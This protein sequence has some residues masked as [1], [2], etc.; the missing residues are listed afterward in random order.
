MTTRPRTAARR[1]VLVLGVLA[2]VA[3]ACTG[4]QADEP[5]KPGEGA[6]VCGSTQRGPAQPPDD[7]VVV[8]PDVPADLTTA[9]QENPAGTTFWL[10]TGT[11]ILGNGE[12]DQVAPKNGNTYLAAPGA[13]LDGRETNRYAF[14]GKAADVTITHLTVRG[15][16][17]PVNEGV[18]NHDSGAGWTLEH[19]TLADNA[20]AALMAGDKQVM[21]GNCFRDNGQY[22]LNACCGEITDVTLE[23]NEFVGN[24]VDDVEADNPGCGCT[25]AMKFWDIDGADI[26]GNWIHDNRGPGIWADTNNNDFLIEGNLI[27]DNDGA[28]IIYETSYNAVI[29][30]NTMRR[31][32]WV[33]GREFADNSDNFPVATIYISE[34]GGEPRVPARTDQIEITGNT[35]ENN[36][37]GITLW[38][39]ADRFCNSAANT[40]TGACTLLVDQ[41]KRCSR[42]GITDQPLYDDCRWKTQRVDIH[43]N[44][45]VLD[46]DVVGCRVLCARMAVLANFGTFPDWSPYQ[47]DVVREAITYEQDNRWHANDYRGPWTFLA[48]DTNTSITFTQWRAAPYQQDAGSTFAPVSE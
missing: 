41:P 30:D 47:G 2:I 35:L 28:A 27:E 8:D 11:H 19:N 10:A 4:P 17:P 1:A 44:Q 32:A 23:R 26:I 42:P 15:F 12:Y 43:H 36:W 38:E 48:F 6:A 34:S 37:S 46:P 20:G 31:N 9:T 24:N 22:G 33:T 45:F 5:P 13:I 39:N 21:R 40:S 3:S 16:V 25:G 18:V 14:T 29:K 7:A